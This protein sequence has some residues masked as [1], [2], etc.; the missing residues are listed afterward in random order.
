MKT[1][2]RQFIVQARAWEHDGSAPV[3]RLFLS[4]GHAESDMVFG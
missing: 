4:C 3:L 1:A 2:G